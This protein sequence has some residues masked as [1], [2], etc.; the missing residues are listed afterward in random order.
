MKRVTCTAFI[1]TMLC[2]STHLKAQQDELLQSTDSSVLN[3]DS[4][5]LTYLYNQ[6]HV[7]V[8]KATPDNMKV[9]KPDSSNHFTMP[10]AGKM[11]IIQ[12]P[13]YKDSH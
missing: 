10:V 2:V 12:L 7:D 1:I 11:K 5:K 4:P 6:N 8:Y 3:I 9:I 13:V